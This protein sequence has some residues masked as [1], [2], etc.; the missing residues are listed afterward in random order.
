MNIIAGK[1]EL[2]EKIGS[3]GSATVFLA[4]HVALQRK[5]VLKKLFSISASTEINRLEIDIL[6]NLQ[7]KHLPRVYDFVIVGGYAYSVMEYIP[8]KSLDKL[9]EEG[10]TFKENEIVQW[11]KVLC[12]T[13][14]YLHSQKPP[15]LHCDIK[16]SNLILSEAGEIYLID[17]NI[18]SYI[19]KNSVF[20]Y[21]AKFASPEQKKL[22]NEKLKGNLSSDEDQTELMDENLDDRKTTATMLDER[23]DIYSFG[24]TLFYLLNGYSPNNREELHTKK[25]NMSRSFKKI[26]ERALQEDRDN[27]Y[28]SAKAMLFDLNKIDKSKKGFVWIGL[29][30][31]LIIAV[32]IYLLSDQQEELPDLAG[33]AANY[34]QNGEYE[35]ALL[36]YQELADNEANQ[37]FYNL[38]ISDCY[39]YIGD[40]DRAL[41]YIQ[42]K[43]SE[44]SNELYKNK[45]LEYLTIKCQMTNNVEEKI[46]LEEQRVLLGDRTPEPYLD[47]LQY[48]ASMSDYVMLQNYITEI[49]ERNLDINVEKY[50]E[51]L[52]LIEKNQGMF[53]DL[54][55]ACQNEDEEMIV[56]LCGNGDYYKM[57][58]LIGQ[59]LFYDEGEGNVLGIYNSG[60]L[61]FGE[62]QN[63]VR[64]GHGQWIGIGYSFYVY[65]GE[66]E[67]DMPNG[68][69]TIIWDRYDQYEE[70]ES[71]V[72]NGIMDGKCNSTVYERTDG[73][74]NGVIYSYTYTNKMGY[75]QEYPNN[76]PENLKSSYYDGVPDYYIIVAQADNGDYIGQPSNQ[77]ECVQGLGL[78]GN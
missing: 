10:Y 34:F 56:Q 27:R 52:T 37:E 36:L 15:I 45:V 72:I 25:N 71:D 41:E 64:Q 49:K 26:L 77:L 74:L 35:Q 32:V 23:T 30:I 9:I 12:D 73:I 66:W 63:G 48:Y 11:A 13:L 70:Y 54:Y 16:P 59:P 28:P 2:I 4:N 50:E 47:L 40:T 58:R 17:F 76:I 5:V 60:Y 57:T 38:R 22:A 61:Y 33:Q 78:E 68:H 67:D 53:H 19:E 69:G 46:A 20:G 29:V 31:L 3:G 39:Y 7:N 43:Y 44:D 1:Y 21:T 18:S 8:G 6:K 62:M 75:P 55:G 51:I 14:A 24:T 42:N 65:D